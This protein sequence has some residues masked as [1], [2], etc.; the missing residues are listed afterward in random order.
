MRIEPAFSAE[1][2]EALH[3]HLASELEW[4]RVVNQGDKTWDLGPESIAALDGEQGAAF[5]R[6][7]HDAARDGFQFLFDSVRVSENARERADRGLLLDR[8]LDMLNSPATLAKLRRLVGDDRVTLVDGQATRYLPGHFL[9]GHDD[10]V[11][12]KN[13]IAAYVI[14]LTPSWRTEWG[15]LL[16]FHDARGDVTGALAPAFNAM[17]VF[18]VPQLHS[19]SYVA[20]FAGAPRYS[21][22]GWL[23]AA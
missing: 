17:H 1:A 22:T 10:G 14:N 8:L 16:Q 4:W 21:I 7:V 5:M 2:A 9:T 12:G 15:G 3:R 19:V 6:S 23:R 11:E 20:P 13:R 18:T